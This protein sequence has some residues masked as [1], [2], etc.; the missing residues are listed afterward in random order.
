MRISFSTGS[1]Y[2]MPLRGVFGLAAAA[3]FEGVELVVA[4]EVLGRRPRELRA[5]A[6]DH[7]LAVPVVH[8]P[9]M[10]IPG[11]R[12]R[13]G[14]LPRFVELARA[15]G[16]PCVVV[17][18]PRGC[19][20]LDDERARRF[21]R[22]LE[23]ARRAAGGEVTLAVENLS[24]KRPRDDRNPFNHLPTLAR[25]AEE[26]R[27][28][29]TMDTSHAA[30]FGH[31]LLE[32]YPHF[33]SRLLNLHLSDYRPGSVLVDNRLLY[34]HF[35]QHQIP[36]TGVLPLAALLARLRE[37]RYDDVT[38]VQLTLNEGVYTYHSFHVVG[39]VQNLAG[40]CWVE[41]GNPA[42]AQSQIGGGQNQVIHGDG[43][44]HVIVVLAI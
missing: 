8:P 11:W 21:R 22:S 26:E 41:G 18:P 31:D 44:V 33:G 23:N 2:G 13:R 6:G 39:Q 19:T 38:Y 16:A 20:G 36:G 15:L 14:G 10:P 43:H 3:G 24:R 9:L 4:P 1:L 35:V 30:S 7:G 17:H 40:R 28:G 37:D 42:R 25:F 34:N 27:L 29:M 5:L 32:I 12:E